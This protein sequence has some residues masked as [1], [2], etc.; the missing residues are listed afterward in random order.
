MRPLDGLPPNHV[1]IFLTPNN[2]QVRMPGK[3]TPYSVN[4]TH[5]TLVP[6]FSCT[7]HKSQGQTLAKAI[8]DLVPPKGI[9]NVAIEFAYVPLSRVRRLEDVTIL[10]PFDPSILRVQVHEACTAMMAEFKERD[11]CKDM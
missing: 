10:R 7:S 8:V 4:R 1:P 3:E 11:L 2:F 5:F 6:R 9:K